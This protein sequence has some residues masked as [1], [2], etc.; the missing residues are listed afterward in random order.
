MIVVINVV[1][2]RT[3]TINAA[4]YRGAVKQ[5]LSY[6]TLQRFIN[7]S[8]NTIKTAKAVYV[9]IL[10]AVPAINRRVNIRQSQ[11]HSVTIFCFNLCRTHVK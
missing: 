2:E 9:R 11:K 5:S 7:K 8:K 6:K 10:S 4:I 1:L 3:F